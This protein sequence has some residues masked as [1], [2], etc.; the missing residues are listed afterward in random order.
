MCSLIGV[1]GTDIAL[2]ELDAAIGDVTIGHKS[3]SFLINHNGEVLLHHLLSNPSTLEDISLLEPKEFSEG[4]NSTRH[5]M[6]QR[7]AGLQKIRA[8][9][10]QSAGN[11]KY[12]GYLEYAGHLL[13]I[14]QPVGPSSLSLGIVIY[15]EDDIHAPFV[16]NFG[17]ESVPTETCNVNYRNLSEISNCRWPLNLFNRVDL[18]ANCSE[19]LRNETGIVRKS[20]HLF[21]E[22]LTV[23]FQHAGLFSFDRPRF[24]HERD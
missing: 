9:I 16:P 20:N 11:V 1:V 7:E 10:R 14:Y 3:S 5:A 15:T 6:I 24:Q 8:T 18:I 2:D 17:L 4:S 12:D 23:T 22:N 21:Y 19:T 13:Y